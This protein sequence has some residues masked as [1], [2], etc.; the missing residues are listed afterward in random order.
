MRQRS[1][2]EAM[3]AGDPPAVQAIR[4]RGVAAAARLLRQDGSILSQRLHEE[5]KTSLARFGDHSATRTLSR[6][7]HDVRAVASEASST[8]RSPGW[9]TS[10]TRRRPG[11]TPEVPS[12]RRSVIVEA[13]AQRAA[14]LPAHGAAPRV[15]GVDPR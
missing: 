13:D 12:D 10:C 3:I 5:F 1:N 7:P 2:G 6:R 15:G 14:K 9:S 4:L 11:V 8:A